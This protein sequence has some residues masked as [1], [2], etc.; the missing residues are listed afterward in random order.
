MAANKNGSSELAESSYDLASGN[1]FDW[2]FSDPFK[3]VNNHTPASQR[4]E[5]VEGSRPIFVDHESDRSLSY[6][7][8]REDALALASGLQGLGLNHRDVL[9]LPPT[10]TCPRPEVAPVVMIQLPNTLQ[11]ATALLGSWAA[12][13]SATLVSPAL[14][15]N[16]VA[17]VLQ[18]ARPRVIITADSCVESV[19]E[20]LRLQEDKD[21]FGK[22]PVFSVDVANDNYPLPLGRKPEPSNWRKLLES[23]SSQNRDTPEFDPKLRT[24]LILWSSG[25]SGRPKGVL[26]SHNALN[27]TVASLWHDADFYQGQHQRWLGYVPFYHVFGLTNTFLQAICTGTTVYTMTK[28]KLDAFLAAVPK[29]KVTYLHMAPPIAVMLAKS[30]LVKPY[31]ERDAAGRNAFSTVIGGVTGGA[32]LGHEVIVEVYNRL[33]FR[34]R[35]GYGL[36]ESCSVSVQRGLSQEEMLARPEDTG[37]AHWGVQ[38]MLADEASISSGQTR[39]A[40]PGQAGEILIRSPGNMIGYL[41]FRDKIVNGVPDMSTTKEA[42]TSDGWFRTGDVGTLSPEGHLQITDRIKELIKVR[43]FQ[44]APAELEALLCSSKE[45]A[46]AGVV[47]VYDKDEATELPRAYVVAAGSSTNDEQKRALAKRLKALVEEKTVKYK[48]LKGGIVF[49]DQIPKSPS[50]KILRRVL[51]SGDVKGFEVNL[52]PRRRAISSK[53]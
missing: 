48:W 4:L 47:A 49:V 28:F 52:Y 6:S 35:R 22:V 18:H 13:M 1:V 3:T 29:R 44:V 37:K 40:S 51:K 34:V 32:P 50:G 43:A 8:L 19:Q 17:W 10:P 23:S 15:S 14:T 39:A 16:E 20:A 12:G 24:A 26:I 25:T 33:G 42:L 27:F 31:A 9:T 36:T 41:P 11:F 30:P 21:Y 2:L 5:L 46:D 45:V 7:Q 38:L 53:L